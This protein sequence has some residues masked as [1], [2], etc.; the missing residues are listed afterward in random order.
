MVRNIS[1]RQQDYPPFSITISSICVLCSAQCL[2]NL[3]GYLAPRLFARDFQNN[4]SK[5]R[6]AAE[7]KEIPGMASP[8]R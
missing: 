4:H 8:A 1:K 7:S 5:F 3:P 6:P 2:L